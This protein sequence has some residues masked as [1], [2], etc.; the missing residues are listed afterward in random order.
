MLNQ[1]TTHVSNC[2]KNSSRDANMSQKK[3]FF[4]SLNPYSFFFN[5]F[6]G[7]LHCCFCHGGLVDYRSARYLKFYTGTRSRFHV[8]KN[9]ILLCT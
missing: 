4:N 6:L 9:T 8:I 3:D 5:V 7:R 2:M 1:D